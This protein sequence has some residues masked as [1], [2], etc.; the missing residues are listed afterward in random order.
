MLSF[1]LVPYISIVL[2]LILIRSQRGYRKEVP[3]SRS[4]QEA[5]QQDDV[6]LPSWPPIEATDPFNANPQ[7]NTSNGWGFNLFILNSTANVVR[8]VSP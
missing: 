4:P 3:V 7:G 8:F 2:F 6:Y 5:P 1:G